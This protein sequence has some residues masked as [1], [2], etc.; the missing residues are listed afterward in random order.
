MN[1]SL[2]QRIKEFEQHLRTERRLSPH[3]TSNYSRDLKKLTLW[4]SKKS[5]IEP[6]QLDS[7]NIRECLMTLHREGL[8]GRSIQRWLS[9]LRTFFNYGLKNQW[10]S[11]NPADGIV[12]PKSP[13]KLPKTLDV[14]QV[15]Q[16]LSLSATSWIDYRDHAIIELLYSSGL[17]RTFW[18]RAIKIRAQKKCV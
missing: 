5:L 16:F 3:T 2:N 13:K 17:S 8:G 12:A 9:S 6:E 4:C 18:R 14:D 15:N 10:I 7:Q 1:L 11:F